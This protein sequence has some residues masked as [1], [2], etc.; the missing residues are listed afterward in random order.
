MN[1][2]DRIPGMRVTVLEP[3][4]AC[5]ER[6]DGEALS[7]LAPVPASPEWA[8]TAPP[9]GIPD[10]GYARE[11]AIADPYAPVFEYEVPADGAVHG[12]TPNT[13][14][15]SVYCLS[16]T[17]VG[18]TLT[19]DSNRVYNLSPGW[20]GVLW[21]Q[22][23]QVLRVKSASVAAGSV[24]LYLMPRRV[25]PAVGTGFSPPSAGDNVNPAAGA[26]VALSSPPATLNAGSA[27]LLTFATPVRHV[28]VQNNSS[29]SIG[30]EFDGTTA[31]AGSFQVGP[32][33]TYEA[34]VSTSQV[35]FLSSLATNLNGSSANNVVLRGRA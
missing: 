4:E 6:G 2:R 16:L 24:V 20:S 21:V 33:Q 3:D 14:V 5:N 12:L 23:T 35:S 10:Q 26:P 8:P 18:V 11:H 27:T 30:V 28:E 31:T 13:T 34:D 17:S 29:V 19:T 32:G 1:E 15:R 9:R 25:A 22:A 7:L